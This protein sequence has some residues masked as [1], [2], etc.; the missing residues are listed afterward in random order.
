MESNTNS[1]SS[2]SS[3]SSEVSVP[4]N[5]PAS[6][7][8]AIITFDVH[9]E[10]SLAKNFYFLFDCSGSMS[11]NCSGKE[12][13]KGAKEAMLRFLK[14][15]PTDANTGLIAF[16]VNNDLGCKEM[17]LLGKNDYSALEKAISPLEPT[18]KTP[19]AEAIT[20]GVDRLVK[21]YK[22]QL[23]YG[24]YRLIVITDGNNTEGNLE[25]SCK[26]LARYGFI[27]L[28]SIGLCMD[29]DNPL[30]SVALSSRDASNYEEL[31]KALLETAAETDVF[32]SSVFDSTLFKK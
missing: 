22:K 5:N 21:Q 20:L 19:L 3:S 15:I 25:R 12:K 27:S 14:Q 29:T 28:Y 18:G 16:G 17:L 24:E 26:N 31:E 32:D 6:V 7:E 9:G 11:E 10:V 8:Q 2:S 1:S 30:K 13:I 4:V 23:G